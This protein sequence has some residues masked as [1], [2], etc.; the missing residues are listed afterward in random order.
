VCLKK[1]ANGEDEAE[2]TDLHSSQPRRHSNR[3]G[4]P[5][6]RNVQLLI[7]FVKAGRCTWSASV[8]RPDNQPHSDY[9]YKTT[10]PLLSF[11]SCLGDSVCSSPSYNVIV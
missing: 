7:Q 3:L 6:V 10:F 4:K 9:L 1:V 5:C 11:L 8:Q 2:G